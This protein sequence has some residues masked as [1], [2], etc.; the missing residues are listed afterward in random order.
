MSSVLRR[1]WYGLLRATQA[2]AGSVWPVLSASQAN[3]NIGAA[4]PGRSALVLALP[5][6]L[7]GSLAGPVG[8]AE[9]EVLVPPGYGEPASRGPA[10]ASLPT[11]G[12][13]AAPGPHNGP[14][15][16]LGPGTAPS[17]SGLTLYHHASYAEDPTGP[18]PSIVLAPGFTPLLLSPASQPGGLAPVEESS[19]QRWGS[20]SSERNGRLT[21]GLK[22]VLGPLDVAVTGDYGTYKI[23]VSPDLDLFREEK[24]LRLGANLGVGELQVR[25]SMGAE[26][27]PFSIGNTLA[28]DLA[29][30]FN[31]GPWAFG[32]AYTHSL[33]ADAPSTEEVDTLGTLQSGMR[34]AITPSMSAGAHAMFWNLSDDESSAANDVAGVLSFS[35]RF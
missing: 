31:E 15:L 1:V 4:K 12:D 9:T 22:Q 7:L 32:V 24:L 16:R 14:S 17:W 8:A 21:F 2:R 6:L 30:T 13:E 19:A 33:L 29:A 28:W 25:S 5:T 26:I 35:M 10:L 11:T 23:P 20:S 18:D 34:Y 27:K 3:P